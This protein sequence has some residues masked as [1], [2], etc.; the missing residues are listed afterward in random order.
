MIII[1]ILTLITVFLYLWMQ[2]IFYRRLL[3][4]DAKFAK[5]KKEFAGLIVEQNSIQADNAR[6]KHALEETLELYE[7]TK[8]IAKFL[9]AE[10]VF[11][12][13]N[14]KIN[15]YLDLEDCKFLK[16]D[17][18]LSGYKDYQVLPLNIDKKNIGYLVALGIRERDTEKFNILAQQFMLGIKRAVLYHDVQE[19][20]TMDSLTHVFSRRY[21]FQRCSEEINRSKKFN[22]SLSCLM[23]DIDHFKDFNDR[24]GHLIGDALLIETSKTI[25][26][27]I[28]QIDL[29]GKYGG[30]E[31][32]VVLTET[33][34]EGAQ[35][36]AERIRKAMEEKYV[37][38]YDEELK[39]TISIGIS[40]FPKDAQDL[41]ILIDKADQALYRAKE[42][43]R[44][45]V[46][47]Y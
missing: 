21:W 8:E 22:Y 24:Y 46:C 45:R 15:K 1:I 13:F 25:K 2:K 14:E 39:V 42:T 27:N 41:S 23:L 44:N 5:S 20:A 4:E 43:G 32:C 40:A 36:V 47:I 9:D 37:R 28:R 26:D 33:D 19:M 35:F 18:D 11:V 38:A 7:I 12:T 16:S 3:E 29:V 31:F 34:I 6:F 10:K 30:E 17:A